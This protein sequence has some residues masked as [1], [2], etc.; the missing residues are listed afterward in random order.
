MKFTIKALFTW[1]YADNHLM[2]RQFW[3]SDLICLKA[4]M[5]RTHKNLPFVT[6][7]VIHEF[8]VFEELPAY[9]QML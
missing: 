9:G 3:I 4:G 5:S 7:S 8:Y 2:I 1:C 6:L